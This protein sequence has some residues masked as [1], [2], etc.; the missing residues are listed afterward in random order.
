MYNKAVKESK[1]RVVRIE[2]TEDYEYDIE[3]INLLNDYLVETGA[4]SVQTIIALSKAEIETLS[5]ENLDKAVDVV[6]KEALKNLINNNQSYVKYSKD[7]DIFCLVKKDVKLKIGYVTW[8]T[9]SITD[10]TKADLSKF[11]DLE[12]IEGIEYLGQCS[13]KSDTKSWHADFMIE[14]DGNVEFFNAR[15]NIGKTKVRDMVREL[16]KEVNKLEFK[17]VEVQQEEKVV[18]ASELF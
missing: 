7:N 12:G 16:R 2:F 13:G 15:F 8:D 10:A 11:K 9:F 4:V 17:F 6:G 3:P 5:R 14:D 18:L 1:E